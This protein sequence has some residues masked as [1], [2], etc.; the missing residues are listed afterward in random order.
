MIYNYAD[1]Y[2]N[3]TDRTRILALRDALIAEGHPA[4]EIRFFTAPGRTELGGNHTDHQHGR[5]LAA[6]VDVDTVAA[7][8]FWTQRRTDRSPKRASDP[9]SRA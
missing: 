9:C 2:S 7:A 5:V 8:S 4:E 3:Q 1:I 6:A